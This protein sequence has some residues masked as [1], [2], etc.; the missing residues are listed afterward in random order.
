M[1]KPQL[2]AEPSMEDILA[3]IRKMISEERMGPRPIPDQM[4]RTSYGES[5]PAARSAAPAASEARPDTRTDARSERPRV[6]LRSP[7][8]GSAAARPDAGRSSGARRRPLRPRPW[9]SSAPDRRARPAGAQRARA[10]SSGTW[11]DRSRRRR[12]G[13]PLR[14]QLQQPV[15]RAEGCQIP[16]RATPLAGGENRR[17]ARDRSRLA[18]AGCSPGRSARRVLR[19]PHHAGGGVRRAGPPRWRVRARCQVRPFTRAGRYQRCR[20]ARQPEAWRSGNGRAPA[21]RRAGQADLSGR[22]RFRLQ[23]RDSRP[24]R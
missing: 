18:G 15:R 8:R 10:P 24:G 9:R 14:P 19:Q 6:A 12:A 23:A 5:S 1:T 7:P 17:H 16:G 3:S 2:S 22:L 21:R 20:R 11:P 13:R 4:S